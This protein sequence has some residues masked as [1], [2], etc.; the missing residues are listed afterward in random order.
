MPPNNN[1]TDEVPGEISPSSV[2]SEKAASLSLA[3]TVAGISLPKVLLNSPNPQATTK[4]NLYAIA[5]SSS[6]GAFTTRTACPNFEH[7]DAQHQWRPWGANNGFKA[8]PAGGNTINCLGYSPHSFEYY[9]QAIQDVQSLVQDKP[10]FYSISGYAEEI[11]EMLRLA[12]ERFADTADKILME[13]NLSCPNI[14]GKP[15]IAY[16]FEGMKEYLNTALA[17]GTHGLKVGVKLTPY[18]YDGQFVVATEVLNSFYPRLSFVT[19]INTVGCGLVVDTGTEAPIL[20]D[21]TSGNA[22]FGG[23]GG[24]AVH[25]TALGNVRRMRQLLRPEIDVVGCGGVNS[26][27]AAFSH[28][29]CGAQAVMVASALLIEGVDVFAKIELEL[30]D[31]M[32]R[33]GYKSIEDFRGKLKDGNNSKTCHASKKQKVAAEDQERS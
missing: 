27:A 3:T 13:I 31:I 21:A 2:S 18:F 15:P 8:M 32:K 28:L 22:S 26:G 29:L 24:P 6:T 33:K 25:A 12:G 19:C 1:D 7:D 5:S 10:A 20:G 30:Q 4:E 23:L 17:Q 11:A 9:G 16:D 14:P